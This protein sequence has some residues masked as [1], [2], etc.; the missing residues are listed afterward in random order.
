M[1]S[2]QNRMRRSIRSWRRRGRQRESK[3]GFEKRAREEKRQAKKLKRG[4]NPWIKDFGSEMARLHENPNK[5]PVSCVRVAKNTE[6]I[7]TSSHDSKNKMLD[8]DEK[9]KG[10][11]RKNGRA[12][13]Y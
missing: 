7:V 11:R 1:I 4:W 6:F 9:Q 3:A 12:A 5:S 8:A 10:E 2:H 13:M